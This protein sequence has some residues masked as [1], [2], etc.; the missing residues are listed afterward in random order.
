LV[1]LPHVRILLCTHNGKKWLHAQLESYLAQSH[2][3]WSLWVSDD[4]STD[5]TRDVIS[6]FA[7]RHPGKVARFLQG[8]RKGSAA[9]F[10]SLLC[11]PDLPV[12]PVALS[13]QDDVWLPNRLSTALVALEAAGPEPCAWAGAYYVT[14][15][16]LRIKYIAGRWPRPP[17]LGNALV[18][19]VL[20][21]HTL[22]LNEQAVALVR[23]AGVQHVSH[24][25]WWIY[26]LL[27]ASGEQALA[28]M[29]PV[30][31]YRQH[32]A[33]AVGARWTTLGQISRVQA[34]WR[35]RLRD[36]ID[37]NMT[38]LALC[39]PLLTPEAVLLV[40]L[41]QGGARAEMLRT[42][43]AFRQSRLET[44]LLRFSTRFGRL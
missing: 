30:L 44:A 31:L 13:D 37:E 34:L 21:G 38:A 10:L 41:W 36:W 28:D 15:A 26:L 18:Q 9:N 42:G 40:D 19:N 5:S 23:Q 35:G 32:S 20:S 39:K 27:M 33:N 6:D 3:D 12:G 16:A 2:D 24:H 22:T 8:P 7:A 14:D 43:G 29:R 4:G 17:S 25:D 11:H 1:S